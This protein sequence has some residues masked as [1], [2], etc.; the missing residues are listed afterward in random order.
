MVTGELAGDR[1][2]RAGARGRRGLVEG[3]AALQ[4]EDRAAGGEDRGE[5]RGRHDGADAGAAAPALLDRG[6]RGAIRGRGRGGAAGG[7]LAPRRGRVD[8]PALGAGPARTSARR[9]AGCRARPMP[10]GRPAGDPGWGHSGGPRRAGCLERVGCLRPGGRPASVRR[11]SWGRASLWVMGHAGPAWSRATDK[12]AGS[13][14]TGGSPVGEETST[15]GCGVGAS[16]SSAR[17]SS[18]DE[19]PPWLTPRGGSGAGVSTSVTSRGS[20]G[21]V[22]TNREPWPTRLSTA[23]VPWCM[24]RIDLTMDSPSPDPVLRTSLSDA[25]R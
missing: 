20:R 22:T 7:R 5:Q 15:F 19:P 14:F 10:S 17:A 24:S 13:R 2:R 11:S 16:A 23:M 6:G 3:A 4:R 18:L 12:G 21:S 1:L 9:W 25:P 8:R